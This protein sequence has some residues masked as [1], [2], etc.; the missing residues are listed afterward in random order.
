VSS[1]AEWPALAATTRVLTPG[2]LIV[3]SAETHEGDGVILRDTL[4]YAHSQTHVRQALAAAG[5]QLVSLDSA[6]ARSEKG[7]P[8]P[9]LVGVARN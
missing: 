2:G 8:V 3:F 4:R 1:T 5:M 7:V 6:P 9:G